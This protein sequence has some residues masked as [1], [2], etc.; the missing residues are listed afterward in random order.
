L[1]GVW[2]G[3]GLP[4]GDVDLELLEGRGGDMRKKYSQV[5]ACTIEHKPA[6][7]RKPGVC[8]DRQTHHLHLPRKTARESNPECLQTGHERKPL[9]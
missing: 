4:V 7:V 2:N 1:Q 6:K 3:V 9:E 5:G 8:P